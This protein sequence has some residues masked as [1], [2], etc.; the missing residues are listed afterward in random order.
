LIRSHR[1]GEARY[2]EFRRAA[3]FELLSPIW[4]KVGFGN[5]IYLAELCKLERP[6]RPVGIDL[7]AGMLAKAMERVGSGANLVRGDAVALPFKADCLDLVIRSHVL[8]FVKELGRCV[9]DIARS[10]RPGG[11]LDVTT[12]PDLLV[13]LRGIFGEKM[14]AEFDRA[15]AGS[16]IAGEPA[17]S[18]E[19]YR[20]ACSEAGLERA[21][22][23]R[24]FRVGATDRQRIASELSLPG[25]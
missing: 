14:F 22:D 12:A 20:L 21:P 8:L 4:D 23:G 16:P 25:S 9:A 7:S 18:E 13:R 6:H 10:L 11:L 5:G 19:D 3:V 24:A 1:A 15:A 17:T 2:F